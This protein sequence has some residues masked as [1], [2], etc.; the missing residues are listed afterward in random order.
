MIARNSRV[1]SEKLKP[2]NPALPKHAQYSDCLR[3][4]PV[5]NYSLHP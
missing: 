1:H 5:F 2:L 4:N 3:L